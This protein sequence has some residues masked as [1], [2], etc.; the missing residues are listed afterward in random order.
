MSAQ[1]DY[2]RE[3]I[4][5]GAEECELTLTQEQ[6][7]CLA[8]SAEGGHE[9]YGIA[10]PSPPDNDRI[11]DI[12]REKEGE[13]KITIGVRCRYWDRPEFDEIE[14]PDDCSEQEAEEAA[15]LAAMELANFDWWIQP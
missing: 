6:L 7:A 1:Q 8:C 12:E 2:W 3:W 15:L 11:S 14:I 10:F 5:V 4:T 13:M 9:H